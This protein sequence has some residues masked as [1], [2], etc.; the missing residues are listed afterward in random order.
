MKCENLCFRS[1]QSC[2][3]CK[4]NYDV[5]SGFY[6]AERPVNNQYV[7]GYLV[8]DKKTN[9]IAGILNKDNDFNEL[10]WIKEDTLEK[11]PL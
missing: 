10:A 9:K 1:E 5:S 6:R 4:E 8:R 2:V 7:T 11:V 3:Y